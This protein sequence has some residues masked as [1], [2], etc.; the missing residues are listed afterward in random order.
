MDK[1]IILSEIRRTIKES[2]NAF[3]TLYS[4]IDD[5]FAKA[6][7][8]ILNSNKIFI[9]GVGKS[10]IIA[11]KIAATFSSIG[12]PSFF[13]NPVEALHGDIGVLQKNDCAI[14]LSKTEKSRLFLL[15]AI[16]IPTLHKIQ[17]LC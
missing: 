10:G 6:V 2:I 5:N 13:L 17:I 1:D 14:F 12:I 16:A 4:N 9:S 15:S 3:N 11:R 8:L 7:E